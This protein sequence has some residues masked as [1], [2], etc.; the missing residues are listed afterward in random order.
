LECCDE[1]WLLVVF[2]VLGGSTQTEGPELPVHFALTT[3]FTRVS[4]LDHSANR[5]IDIPLSPPVGA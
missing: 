2:E 1:V 4:C 3:R 5:C